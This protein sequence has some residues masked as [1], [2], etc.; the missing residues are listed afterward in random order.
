MDISSE[1]KDVTSLLP[2]ILKALFDFIGSLHSA[3]RDILNG[4]ASSSEVS[5][6]RTGG[7][8]RSGSLSGMAG[9]GRKP[10]A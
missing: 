9:L 10:L 2:F 8:S 3:V 5:A 7:R 1:S 4:P 6:R